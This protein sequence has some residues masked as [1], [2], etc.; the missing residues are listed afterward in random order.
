MSKYCYLLVE[1][2]SPNPEEYQPTDWTIYGD[3]LKEAI[4]DNIDFWR[5]VPDE[6][7]SET[8]L[9]VKRMI[10]D[11]QIKVFYSTERIETYDGK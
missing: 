6:T 9:R 10:K 1:V 8:Y 5:D 7:I 4:M 3:S 11:L 2:E